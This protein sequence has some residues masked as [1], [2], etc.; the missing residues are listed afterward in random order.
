MP[1]PEQPA[2]THQ[3]R[4]FQTDRESTIADILNQ[5]EVVAQIENVIERTQKQDE[6]LELLYILEAETDT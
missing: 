1:R 6:L 3:P 4:T 2:S 5:L